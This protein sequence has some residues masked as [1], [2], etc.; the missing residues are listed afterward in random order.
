MDSAISLILWLFLLAYPAIYIFRLMSWKKKISYHIEKL[1]GPYNYPIIGTVY[2]ILGIPREELFEF[3]MERSRT[4]GR[5]FRTWNAFIP[6]VHLSKP[7]HMELVMTNIKHI[8][9]SFF[10]DFIQPWLGDGLLTSK[11]SKWHSRRKLITPTFHFNILETFVDVFEEKSQILLKVLR[12]KADGEAFDIHPYI[13]RCA[14]DIICETAMGTAVN[15]QEDADSKY[16]TSVITMSEVIMSQIT[17]PWRR[18]I[19]LFKFTSYAKLYN[20]TLQHLHDF[21]LK[22]IREKQSALEQSNSTQENNAGEDDIY[23]GKKKRLAFLD[24]LLKATEGGQKLSEKDLREEVD[25]FMF[26]GHDTTTAGIC[27]AIFLLGHH[28]SIQDKVCE[29]LDEIFQGSDRPTTLRDLQQ[30]KYLE[31]VIKETLRLYPSVPF[32]GRKLT[33]DT[34]IDGYTIPAGCNL[35]L[36]IYRVHRDPD[37]WGPHPENFDPDHFLPER[38]Q[39]RHP[40]AYVPFSGG[41]RNCIGQKFAVLEEK[42]VLSNL[43]RKYRWESVEKRE[44]VRVVSELILRPLGGIFVKLKKK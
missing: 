1:P 38:I 32:I 24:L 4:F 2:E 15:A 28:P 39:G 40:F 20:E 5:L 21:T 34:E 17:K 23:L 37:V 6:E 9:K 31:M 13:T 30:M 43:L 7:E 41:Q 11:G 14:L 44:D 26:E 25:T 8:E 12:E 35:T 42:A 10:Y 18:I 19:R 16:V 3:F 36:H 29:E 33:E 22:V 27:W